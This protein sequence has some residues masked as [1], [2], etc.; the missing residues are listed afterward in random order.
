VFGLIAYTV[1]ERRKELA[2]RSALG[3][4]PSH[5]ARTALASVLLAG[6]GLLAGSAAAY[7]S[8]FVAPQPYGVEPLDPATFAFAA[9]I[10]LFVSVAAAL[11]PARRAARTN[12]ALI[13][14][15]E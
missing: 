7:L 2:I 1:A 14:R 6:F 13:L 8:R 10:C 3:A 11:A 12:P 9:A 5:L 15:Q 4:R